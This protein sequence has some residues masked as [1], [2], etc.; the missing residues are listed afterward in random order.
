MIKFAYDFYHKKYLIMK[1][2][3]LQFNNLLALILVLSGVHQARAQYAFDWAKSVGG[4][5]LDE[6]LS[7]TTDPMGNV[8]VAGRFEDTVDFNP[9]SGNF[10]LNTKGGS[11]AFVLKLDAAGNFKWAAQMGG[12]M[13][14]RAVS[15][16][17][18]KQ[19]NVYT[20]GYFEGTVDF[21]PD[22][23]ATLNLTAVAGADFFISK[24]DSSGKLVWAKT[25]GGAAWDQGIAAI[26]VDDSGNVYT[27]GFFVG[28]IDLN[29]D[30]NATYNLTTVGIRDMF[31]SKLDASG[32]FVWASQA[33]GTNNMYSYALAVDQ[34]GNV[35][36]AGS[37]GGSVS[38]DLTSGT[39][40][41]TTFG[42]ND[43]FVAKT[44]A[45][46]KFV[47]AKQI[48]GISAEDAKGIAVDEAANV[49]L[50]GWFYSTVDFD[51]GPN[52]STLTAS[53]NNDIF[54][55]KLDGNGDFK[56]ARRFGD[57]NNDIGTGIALDA[58][59]NVYTTG[60]FNGPVDF[61]PGPDNAYLNFKGVVDIFIS[62]LDSSG[63]YR[64]AGNFGGAQYDYGNAIAVDRSGTI[65]TTGYFQGTAD[66]DPGTNSFNVT[67]KGNEDVF[68]H[69]MIC[70]DTSSSVWTIEVCHDTFTLNETTYLESGTYLQKFP[71]TAGCDSTLVIHLTLNGAV[72]PVISVK[73]FELST[74]L[75]YQSY[76]WL[77]N[78]N[79]IPGATNREYIVTENGSYTV[80][81]ENEAGCIDTSAAYTVSNVPPETGISAIPVAAQ[82]RIHPNPAADLVY[83]TAPFPVHLCI[84]DLQGKIIKKTGGQTSIS[85]RGLA[86]GLYLLR[87]S[88]TTGSLIKVEKLVLE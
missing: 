88:D 68:I 70:A 57:I 40:T 80:V 51:P 46:G 73:E 18:D 81:V 48:G 19:G 44:N 52:S 61:D 38:F 35:Y 83:I 3:L 25:M 15:V 26:K 5:N 31:I 62:V 33:G 34:Q 65:F 9:G 76:Q 22:P 10:I 60:Y 32:E 67:T 42:G 53:G 23:S 39:T 49:Y 72:D 58:R 21:D 86:S 75:T 27:T 14:D 8:I 11:D 56:W 2:R 12:H 71:N 54:V 29:P 37:F 69:K 43:V 85:V 36:T 4:K 7:V 55:A 1:R 20:T 77:L 30:P 45:E 59:G 64:W 87:I 84:T 78:N 24:L 6:G 28:T 50:T 47:W 17:T 66:F 79:A 13:G 82:I 63:N 74:T 16:T 41:F